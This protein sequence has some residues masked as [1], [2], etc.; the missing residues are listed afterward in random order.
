[1]SLGAWAKQE[2]CMPLCTVGTSSAPCNRGGRRQSGGGMRRTCA[3]VYPRWHGEME[4]A[5][6]GHARWVGQ[7]VARSKT[8]Q[9]P[10]FVWWPVWE[11]MSTRKLHVFP[12]SAGST[13]GQRRSLSEPSVLPAVSIKFQSSS[14]SSSSFT[15]RAASSWSC[16]RVMVSDRLRHGLPLTFDFAPPA[17]SCMCSPSFATACR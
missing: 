15:C 11:L 6:R 10:R 8:G 9:W 4:G 2:L 12:E 17:A 5:T 1:M 13:W 16:T 7:R 3:G 14:S